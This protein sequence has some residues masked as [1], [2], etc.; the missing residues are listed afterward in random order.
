MV[1]D[2]RR[3]R[4]MQIAS[5]ALREGLGQGEL[6]AQDPFGQLARDGELTAAPL[7]AEALEIGDLPRRDRQERAS[8]DPTTGGASDRPGGDRVARPS[9]AS[10]RGPMLV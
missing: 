2:R 6:A 7:A 9:L 8:V 1:T 4:R 5:L 10:R 3:G